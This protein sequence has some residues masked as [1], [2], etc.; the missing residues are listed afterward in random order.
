MGRYRHELPMAWYKSRGFAMGRLCG[1][2]YP[3]DEKYVK[4]GCPMGRYRHELPIERQ[5]YRVSRRIY[6]SNQSWRIPDEYHLLMCTR[7]VDFKPRV[8][9]CDH[10]KKKTK[11]DDRVPGKRWKKRRKWC[12][13]RK[14]EGD[15]LFLHPFNQCQDRVLKNKLRCNSTQKLHNL[16]GRLNRWYIDQS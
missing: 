7:T 12:T 11:Y 15:I 3:W 13:E 4:S 6:Q 1:K 10:L 9:V 16:P 8:L 14:D 2:N 5:V